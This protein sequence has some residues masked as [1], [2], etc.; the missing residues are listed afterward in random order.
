VPRDRFGWTSASQRKSAIATELTYGA[1]GIIKAV[2]WRG[3][4]RG[5]A[6]QIRSTLTCLL[7][8]VEIAGLRRETP[9]APLQTG[10]RPTHVV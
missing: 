3:S 7:C 9:W 6:D 4:G 8:V 2:P 1:A 10:R 5:S